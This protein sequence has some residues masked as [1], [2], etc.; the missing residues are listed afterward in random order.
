MN[1]EK[2]I[3]EIKEGRIGEKINKYLLLN[4]SITA[5]ELS[6]WFFYVENALKFI[7]KA[8][9]CFK[10]IIL[11]EHFENNFLF[12]IEK[13]DVKSIGFIFGIFEENKEECFVTEYS[14][15]QTSL[16][17]IF[18]KFANNKNNPNEMM[19]KGIIIN[20]LLFH[21][22]LQEDNNFIN[23]SVI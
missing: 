8:K 17:Q 6:D 15:Q 10:K 21:N 3:D 9:N 16:E 20:D 22:I 4:K 2:Y 19:D 23:N 1:K 18:L 5:S 13:T 7:E 14:I 11:L 12:K